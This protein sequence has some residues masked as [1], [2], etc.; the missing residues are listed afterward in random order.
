MFNDGLHRY[1]PDLELLQDEAFDGPVW[2]LAVQ[3]AVVELAGEMEQ[4]ESKNGDAASGIY[5]SESFG[6]YQYSKQVASDGGQAAFRA[7][8]N[9]YRKLREI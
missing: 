8:L 6:G 2:A 3:K 4:W 7:Q 5:Q 1:G 9:P